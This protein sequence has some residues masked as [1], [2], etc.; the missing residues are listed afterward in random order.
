MNTTARRFTL[1]VQPLINEAIQLGYI[2]PEDNRWNARLGP[3]RRYE[4]VLDWNIPAVVEVSQC[5][6]NC[7]HVRWAL[8][9]TV[10]DVCLNFPFDARFW[11]GEAWGTAYVGGRG[12][13]LVLEDIGR[14]HCRKARQARLDGISLVLPDSRL[15]SSLIAAAG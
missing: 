4:T 3:Y 10:P 2:R 6:Q 13:G 1:V 5:H 8:W 14:F 12:L 11:A 9:P 7:W 15:A